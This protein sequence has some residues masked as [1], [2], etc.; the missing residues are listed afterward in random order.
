MHNLESPGNVV[1]RLFALQREERLCVLVL[2]L[3]WT[4]KCGC[5]SVCATAFTALKK[6]F[7]LP[8]PKLSSDEKTPKKNIKECKMCISILR[9]MQFFNIAMQHKALT[10]KRPWRRN[11]ILPRKDESLKIMLIKGTFQTECIRNSFCPAPF[12]STTT[13]F[14]HHHHHH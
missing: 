2:M 10:T 1:D 8:T 11:K 4:W 12:H 13:F 14:V 6:G 7:F 9:C 5:K 3:N